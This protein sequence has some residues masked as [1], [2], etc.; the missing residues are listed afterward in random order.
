MFLNFIKKLFKIN[1]K[2]NIKGCWDE[3]D[4]RNFGAECIAG[5]VTEN[6]LTDKNFKTVNFDDLIDQD[7][8]D[9]CV[10]CSGAY[11]KEATEGK[12]MS[13][14]GLYAL[15]CKVLG[16][17]PSFGMSILAM[18][19]ARVKYGIPEEQYYPYI[20]SKYK[21]N[22]A[23]WRNLT[24][25]ALDNA[26]RHKD[27]SYFQIKV[28]NGM[29]KFDAF[30]GYLNKLKDKKVVINTGADS[31]AISLCGQKTIN[32]ELRIGGPDSYGNDNKIDYRLGVERNGWRWFNK[33]EV[34]QFFNGY[35]GNDMPREIAELLNEYN[36]KAVK[37]SDSNA[38]YYIKGGKKHKLN[39]EAIA[40]A[41]N[42][43]LFHPN[44]VYV[45]TEEEMNLIPEGEP[46]KY[47][48][49]PMHEVVQRILEKTAT[50]NQEGIKKLLEDLNK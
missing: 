47:K 23:N 11:A 8:T 2:I 41:F 46:M 43:L 9:F 1:K 49:G 16:Y 48:D 18:M 6:D 37:T 38:C 21:N 32:G 34:S 14:A 42:T 45:I 50:M 13:W 44:N 29:S 27:S 10:A 26:Y 40:W 25:E 3:I 36:E 7:I 39:N 33:H 22:L 31:H 19:K 15:S 20:K 28:P 17:I 35:I 5:Q 4:E 12:K 24:K 30:R